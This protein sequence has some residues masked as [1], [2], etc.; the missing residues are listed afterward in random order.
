MKKKIIIIDDHQITIDGYKGAINRIEEGYLFEIYDVVSVEQF[1]KLLKKERENIDIVIIDIKITPSIDGRIVSG[2][3]L[4]LKVRLLSPNCKIIIST[5]LTDAARISLIL[6]KVSPDSLLLKNDL[7]SKDLINAIKT[8]LNGGK[9]FSDRVIEISKSEL[10]EFDDK[11]LKILY[12]L[13][14]NYKMKDLPS[15]VGLAKRTIEYR[16]RVMMDK[17]MIDTNDD[18]ILIRIA[19]E[20]GLL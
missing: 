3:D 12:F 18:A 2:E 11:D 5:L 15:Y 8:V 17:L 7:R 10:L 19:K 20:K 14:Q 1:M 13:S 9:Y 16:K 4:A 6:K